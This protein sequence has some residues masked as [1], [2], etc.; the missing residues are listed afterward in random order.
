MINQTYKQ[1]I[2]CIKTVLKDCEKAEICMVK[3]GNFEDADKYR[4]WVE[5]LK[6]VLYHLKT[7][8]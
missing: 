2:K 5:A 1:K 6:W 4:G 8:Y 3:A 7:T